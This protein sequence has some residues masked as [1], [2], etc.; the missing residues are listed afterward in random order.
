MAADQPISICWLRR[1]LRLDDSAALYYALKSGQPVLPLF[2]FDRAILDPL[3]DRHDRRVSFIHQQLHQLQKQLTQMGSTLLVYYDEPIAVWKQVLQTFSVAAVYTNTDYETYAKQRDQRVQE[4]LK[5]AGIQLHTYKDQA[6]FDTNEVLTGS[7]TPYSVFGAYQRKWKDTLTD[8]YV[9][10]YPTES[11]FHHFH[12]RTAQPI[13]S[14]E[15]M[16]FQEVKEDFP[17]TQVP[18]EV[19]ENYAKNRDK[20]ALHGTTELSIHLRFGTISI[21]HLV[22]Q[23]QAQGERFLTELIWRDFY[24][25]ILDHFPHVEHKPFRP[26]YEAIPWLN[27]SEDIERWQQGM[28]GYPLVDAGMR[29]LNQVGWMH[30][31]ARLNAASFCIKHLLIDWRIGEAYFAE[32]LRDYD[33]SANNG[34]WQWVAGS[35][36]DA[37]PF[38]RVFNPI[39]QAKKFDPKEEYIR[40]WVPEYGTPDYP[41]PIIEHG[42]ARQRAIDTYR[43][44]LRP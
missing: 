26:A 6:I 44:A 39:S 33:L 5:E 18:K 34:N 43:K 23:A 9:R 7:K 11:Y 12:K 1:D 8:F 19:L 14:L 4:L 25:Q 22:Q 29:Q 36:N 21:R 35:G 2:I 41:K 42:F 10:S 38:F 28:T 24:F 40:Q 31:R 3:A 16:N 27:R 37:S 13:P 32:K 20:P 17:A 30:N 15:S